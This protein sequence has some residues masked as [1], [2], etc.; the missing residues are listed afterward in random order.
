M[1]VYLECFYMN[2]LKLT[3]TIILLLPLCAHAE[4]NMRQVYQAWQSVS[5]RIVT[6][7]VID[8]KVSFEE[9]SA[10]INASMLSNEQKN[11]WIEFYGNVA[12]L[13]HSINDILALRKKDLKQAYTECLRA[14]YKDEHADKICRSFMSRSSLEKA[15]RQQAYEEMEKN[16]NAIDALLTKANN[17][18][19]QYIIDN[20]T[21]Q[22]N[23]CDIEKGMAKQ[24][25]LLCWGNHYHVTRAYFNYET[26]KYDDDSIV[27]F[28]NG[29]VFMFMLEE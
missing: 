25:V 29:K 10:A 20:A 21:P 23:A 18:T 27:G 16:A 24:Q 11:I 5:S 12:R 28:E 1:L 26:W 17:I 19:R 6:K 22:N 9:V 3:W 15:V 7:K 8:G 13:M 4:T 14:N 2:F